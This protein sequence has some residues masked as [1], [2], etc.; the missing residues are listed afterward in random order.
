MAEPAVL[1]QMQ[2]IIHDVFGDSSIVVTGETTADDVDGWDSLT[3][4]QIITAIE[5]HYDLKFKLM[6]VMRFKNVG[7]ICAC[8]E[9]RSA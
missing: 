7:D 3:H 8:I 2:T 5:T 4:I 6:E 9:S 1:A